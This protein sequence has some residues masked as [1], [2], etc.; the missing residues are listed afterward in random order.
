MIPPPREPVG[1]HAVEAPPG[2]D[3]HMFGAALI[4]PEPRQARLPAGDDALEPDAFRLDEP[5][6]IR[7]RVDAGA[8]EEIARNAPLCQSR[9][10]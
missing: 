2:S 10:D 6:E 7:A 4:A 8:V 5:H 3:T 1:G 9:F